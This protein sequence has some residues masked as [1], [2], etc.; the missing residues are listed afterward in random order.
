MA[1]TK[2]LKITLVRSTIG[3]REKHR[4]TV[5]ALGLRKLNNSVVHSATPQILGMIEQVKYL[6]KVEELK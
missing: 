4:R 6:L 5:K 2:K 3:V 1:E